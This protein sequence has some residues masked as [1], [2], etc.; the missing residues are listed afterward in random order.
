MK[1]LTIVGNR[2]QFIKLGV[3]ARRLRELGA[4]APWRSIVVNTGQHYDEMLS[5][6]FFTELEIEAPDYALGIGSGHIFD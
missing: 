1:V 3:T 2:P 5:D 4:D 6:V